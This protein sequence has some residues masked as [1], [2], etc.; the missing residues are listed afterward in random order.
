MAA[1]CPIWLY[2]LSF[3]IALAESKEQFAFT[4]PG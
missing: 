1:C 4:Q 2:R 3:F